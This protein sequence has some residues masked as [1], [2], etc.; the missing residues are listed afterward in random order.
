MYATF[1]ARAEQMQKIKAAGLEKL[2]IHTDGW[3]EQGMT[4]TTPTFYRP[5]RRRAAGTA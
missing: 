4:T 1:E 2:Y 5:A 3:G